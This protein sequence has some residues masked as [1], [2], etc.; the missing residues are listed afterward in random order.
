MYLCAKC[1]T[2]KELR[3]AQTCVCV[4]HV[5]LKINTNFVLY[6][7]FPLNLTAEVQFLLLSVEK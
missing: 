4:H 7:P 2:V 5:S 3:C 1:F 6:S